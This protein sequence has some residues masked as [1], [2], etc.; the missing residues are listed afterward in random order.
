MH[1]QVQGL[2]NHPILLDEDTYNMDK[3]NFI[4]EVAGSIKVIISKYEKQAF[5]TQSGNQE[6]VFLIEAISVG[7]GQKLPLWV[8]F[9]AAQKFKAWYNFLDE[10][11]ISTSHNR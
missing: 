7:S 9:K 1:I 4:I 5:V 3:K 6:W 8:I 10:S 2:Q 11:F